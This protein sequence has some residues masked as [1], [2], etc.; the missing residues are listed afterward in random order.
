LVTGGSGFIGTNL[1][2]ALI[3]KGFVIL[4]VDIT[5]P[6]K[7][8]HEQYWKNVDIL[9]Y[10]SLAK[11]IIS[12]SPD[13]I[14][15][16]AAVTDLNGETLKYYESNITGTQNIIK[17]CTQ[18]IS[19]KKVIFTSS[20]YVCKPGFIPADYDTYMPHTVYGESKVKT[21][22]LVKSQAKLHYDWVIIRPTS[23]WGPWFNIP[24]IDFFNIIYQGKYFDFGRACRKTYGYI[25]NTVYQIIKL[26]ESENVHGKTFY[27]GD[28]PPIQISEWANEI[29]LCMSKGKI[30]SIPFSILKSAAFVGDILTKL[31]L[32]FPITSF[33]LKN[34][35]TDNILPL[36][37][38]YDL[39][40]E[41]PYTRKEGVQK[42]VKWLI[43]HKGYQI[44]NSILKV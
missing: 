28:K 12:F 23:I 44:N 13:V 19:L 22:L 38:L 24:Y 1:I 40:G 43:D 30:K 31:K 27:L 9:N 32:K 42:T 41:P 4:N 39:I 37:N 7:K 29:S 35:T 2:E 25:E 11:E 10:K 34:M 15:H 33:R 21:E 17:I 6:S 18:L 14:I 26:I 20:M 8:A 3:V 5:S 36:D 16:L